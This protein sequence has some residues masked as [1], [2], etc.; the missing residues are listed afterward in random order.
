MLWY[1][2]CFISPFRNWSHEE[3]T[4]MIIFHPKPNTKQQSQVAM[5]LTF[6]ATLYNE[7]K[8]KKTWIITV[9]D[10]PVI[11]LTYSSQQKKLTNKRNEFEKIIMT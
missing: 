5:K 7:L 11:Y 10:Y 1:V 3:F 4:I 8:G 6:R 9:F 2:T